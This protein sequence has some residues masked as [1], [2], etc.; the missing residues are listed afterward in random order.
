MSEAQFVVIL[1][2]EVLFGQRSVG[3]FFATIESVLAK[4]AELK[5]R[6][7][8]ACRYSSA[9]GSPLRRITCWSMSIDLMLEEFAKS[10]VNDE[11]W[12]AT[13]E[14]DTMNDMHTLIDRAEALIPDDYYASI[15][16]PNS[17][18]DIRTL[19]ESGVRF[20]TYSDWYSVNRMRTALGGVGLTDFVSST[21]K[22]GDPYSWLI[23]L[24]DRFDFDICRAVLVSH[25]IGLEFSSK[26]GISTVAISPYGRKYAGKRNGEQLAIERLSELGDILGGESPS[27]TH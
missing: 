24:A 18:D 10:R 25:S 4:D 8:E 7:E 22:K 20:I 6:L 23:G 16:R 11:P 9:G 12:Y 3:P 15:V 13:F 26:T 2:F 1:E 27:V 14:N 17:P 5:E 19:A 21:H